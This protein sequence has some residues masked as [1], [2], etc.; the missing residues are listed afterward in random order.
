MQ[1]YQRERS[2]GI[3][4]FL[5]GFG[6][7]AASDSPLS[8]YRSQGVPNISSHRTSLKRSV[9]PSL[10]ERVASKRLRGEG[11]QT[12]DS[13]GIVNRAAPAVEKNRG[14]DKNNQQS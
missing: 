9:T 7:I 4:T 6:A 13:L 12:V 8:L 14:S 5:R 2:T 1:S 3:G 11:L 10:L